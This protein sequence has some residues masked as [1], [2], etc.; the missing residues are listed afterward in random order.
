MAK[1][2]W[3]SEFQKKEDHEGIRISTITKPLL[4]L[5]MNNVTTGRATSGKKSVKHFH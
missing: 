4:Q 3:E 1:P 2:K 5:N